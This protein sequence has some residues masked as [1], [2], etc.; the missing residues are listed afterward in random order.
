L[1][2]ER[3]RQLIRALSPLA[4]ELALLPQLD[5]PVRRHEHV[6]GRLVFSAYRALEGE[7]CLR[8]LRASPS[9]D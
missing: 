7:P 2:V 6:G 9:A 8:R 1:D 3:A 5:L 4:T